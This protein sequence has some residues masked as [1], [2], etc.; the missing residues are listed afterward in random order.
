VGGV[1]CNHFRVADAMA[2]TVVKQK[3]EKARRYAQE[4]RDMR[5]RLNI[6]PLQR[7]PIDVAKI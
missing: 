4:L 3:K 2:A 5:R 6:M 7:I 1:N